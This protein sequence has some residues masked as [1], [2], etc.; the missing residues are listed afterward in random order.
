MLFF[1]APAV[2]ELLSGSAPPAEF[3]LPPVF[4]VLTVLYGGGA[5]LVREL[6]HRL[7][8]GW[9]TL[10]VLGAAYGIIEEGLM[11]KSFFDPKWMDLG[12]LGDYG[13]WAGVNW[14]WA[15]NLTIYHGV[16]SIA[17]PILLVGI[18]FPAQLSRPWLR[19][20]TLA[21]VGFLFVLDGVVIFL[22][23]APYRPSPITYL[24][25]LALVLGLV[26]L[27]PSLPRG[28]RVRGSARVR[29]G[30]WYGV[31]GFFATLTFF[32]FFFGLPH[33]GLPPVAAML[34]T[35]ALVVAVGWLIL[36]MSAGGTAWSANHQLAL[37]SGAFGVLMLIAVLRES[38]PNP[39]DDPTGMTL[40]ALA[41]A[42]FLIYV[43]VRGR[44][45]E[46]RET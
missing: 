27:A 1:L 30:W 45:M 16:F 37:V 41:C 12:V 32:I 15:L 42:L 29:S 46:P 35:A 21:L 3:F 22:F 19:K 14:V 9:P 28:A 13:R 40:I 17:I 44:Q 31:L 36:S 10:L 11:A 23:M 34:L 26:C 5:L 2:G 25:T 7:G 6:T 33:W 39:P 43:A 20:G 38:A 8:K 4:L 24:I 18:L